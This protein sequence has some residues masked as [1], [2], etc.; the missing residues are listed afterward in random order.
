MVSRTGLNYDRRARELPLDSIMIL[1]SKNMRS[2]RRKNYIRI[3]CKSERG[4]ERESE[5]AGDDPLYIVG[6][7]DKTSPMR[8]QARVHDTQHFPLPSQS[9]AFS[10][11]VNVVGKN[12]VSRFT[13]LHLISCPLCK[14]RE[15]PHAKR[16]NDFAK[17]KKNRD[18]FRI[19]RIR[20]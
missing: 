10:R 9:E 6:A 17:R 13:R 20:W 3:I 15:N 1:R 12:E 11:L 4:K 19:C 14:R 18:F 8:R 16:N 7:A 5:R 2:V